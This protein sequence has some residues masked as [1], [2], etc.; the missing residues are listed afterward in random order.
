[1]HLYRR[2]FVLQFQNAVKEGQFEGR[3][4]HVATGEIKEFR[5]IEELLAFVTQ[6]ANEEALEE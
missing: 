2:S 5:T 4:E 3:V 6:F 1:M